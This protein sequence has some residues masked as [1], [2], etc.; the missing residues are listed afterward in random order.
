[1]SN[2]QPPEV[3]NQDE[4]NPGSELVAD[5]ATRLEE[6]HLG[7]PEVLQEIEAVVQQRS[8]MFAGPNPPPH[9]LAQYEQVCPGWAVRLLE[10]SEREQSWR[11]EKERE[12][13]SQTKLIIEAEKSDR[14][15]GRTIEGRGLTL[16]FIAFLVIAATGVGAL[17][18]HETSAA[19]A[20]FTTFAVGVVGMFVT[21]ASG[22]KATE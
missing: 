9:L 11:I 7:S 14:A 17:L 3:Q 8:F 2:P 5:I 1:M 12:Q 22:K 16:G 15:A 10:Q 4:D 13:L 18:L 6:K 20:C 19:I 21:R